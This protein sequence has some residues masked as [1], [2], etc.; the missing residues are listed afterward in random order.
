MFFQ[1]ISPCFFVSS[2]Y[3]QLIQL[4]SINITLFSK[5]LLQGVIHILHRVFHSRISLYFQGFHPFFPFFVN[6]CIAVF[7][8]SEISFA[9]DITAVFLP[10]FP[11]FFHSLHRLFASSEA[12]KI[13]LAKFKRRPNTGA[14]LFPNVP[15]GVGVQP[16]IR[17]MTRQILIVS[18]GADHSAVITTQL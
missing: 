10:L 13:S 2:I 16:H 1:Q 11:I 3:F 5:T 6:P 18:L 8:F 15:G 14:P 7:P 4:N 17:R 9:L 12:V